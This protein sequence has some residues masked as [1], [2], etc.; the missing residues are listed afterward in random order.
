MLQGEC[1]SASRRRH[2]RAPQTN[3]KPH[4]NTHR[5]ARRSSCDFLGNAAHGG[6]AQRVQFFFLGGEHFLWGE[7]FL[8]GGG[9]GGGDAV[10]LYVT[11]MGSSMASTTDW[12]WYF[13]ATV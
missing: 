13:P 6:E 3:T 5:R 1:E 11:V 9:G 7:R 12:S 8:Q 10:M 2:A 4:T